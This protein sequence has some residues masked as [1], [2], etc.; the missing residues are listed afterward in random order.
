VARG[1]SASRHATSSPTSAGGDVERELE[2]LG[3]ARQRPCTPITTAAL[4]IG[5]SGNWPL[6]GIAVSLGR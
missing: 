5:G 1:G 2:I 4:G 6:R 3:R